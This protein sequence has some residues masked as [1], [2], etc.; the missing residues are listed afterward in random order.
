MDTLIKD[1]RYGMRMLA[2]RPSFTL[3]AVITLALGIGA[4]T[5]I[6]STIDALL[7]RPLNLKDIERLAAVS[8][9]TTHDAFNLST[10]APADF[11]D[12]REQ[13]TVFEQLA[14]YY[15]WNANLTGVGEPERIDG[16]RVT[17]NF[18]RMLGAEAAIGRTLLPEEEQPGR[19]QVVIVSHSFWQRRLE[20]D[21]NIVGS[22]ILLDGQ[23]FTVAGVMPED[24]DFPKPAKLWV[25]IP[26]SNDFTGDRQ[27]QYLNVLGHLKPGV[28]LDQAGAEM[29]AI[30]AR[31][32]QQYPQ[33]NTD[34]RARVALLRDKIAGEFTP[35]FL[36]ILMGAVGFVLLIACVNVAN[37]QLARANSRQKEIAVRSAL[38]ASRRRIVQQMLIESLLLSL[39]GGIAGALF[40][41]WFLDF[42]HGSMPADITRF[43]SGW[44]NL[45]LNGRVLGFNLAIALLTG[46]VFGLVPALQAS[47]PDLNETLKE[48][49][50]GS[51]GAGRGRLRNLLVISEVALSLVL[52]VGAGLMVKGFIRLVENQKQGFNPENLLTLRTTAS[53]SKYAQNH[54]VAAFY[55]QAVER[56]AALPEVASVSLVG[57]LPAS[58]N[59]RSRQFRIEG[60][61]EPAPG[62]ALNATFE[63]VGANYFQTM[64]IP[65]LK[66]REFDERDGEDAPR[67]AIISA[68]MARRYFPDEDPLGKRIK[69]I[70]DMGNQWAAI[71]GVVGDVKRFQ[72]DQQ[73]QPALYFPHPQYPMRGMYFAI[74]ASGEPMS[75]A[76]SVK[77]QIYAVDPEQP[78]YEIYAME[79][80]IADKISGMRL[81]AS[82]MAIFGILALVL[83]AVGVYG[84]MAYSV[85]QRTH[86][87]GV[88]MALGAQSGDVLKM[89]IGQ[90]MKLAAI[91]LGIGLPLA[92]ALSSFMASALFGLVALDVMTFAGITALLV[93]VAM[94]SSYLPARRAARVDPMVALRYE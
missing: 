34:R 82:L 50:R 23:R 51:A 25:P 22:T 59:W 32:E 29:N 28:T 54:Q 20:G 53:L 74:R 61:P 14:G 35:M 5:A 75:L 33:T 67:V 49:G 11:L 3:I 66:G 17:A 92:I 56:I 38:G 76:A 24:F 46:M 52:L 26:L 6:F 86:E 36:W 9:T 30:A 79:K 68:E 80:V 1:I 71:V 37:L 73:P 91:G 19:H 41:L 21:P 85:S 18:F 55:S 77:S 57:N 47:K 70:S 44:E 48:G 78:L 27:G 72:F 12:W 62:E 31:L 58:D 15:F 64:R 63:V 10:V 83:S 7:L 8:E 40:A 84:V 16:A 2:K 45:T 93:G 65:L 42:I 4:N 13:N 43:I 60:R 81:M 87:I 89:V 69:V 94:L 90:A 88:R 39:M